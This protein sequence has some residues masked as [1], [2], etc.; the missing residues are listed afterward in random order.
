MAI[1]FAFKYHHFVREC[2]VIGYLIVIHEILPLSHKTGECSAPKRDENVV[3]KWKIQLLLLECSEAPVVQS[4]SFWENCFFLKKF[5][6][7]GQMRGKR[8]SF[9]RQSMGTHC[10]CFRGE[11]LKTV[12][13]KDTK[14]SLALWNISE[15]QLSVQKVAKLK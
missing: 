7:R 1:I 3:N 6:C 9:P 14:G 11:S 10:S 4:F 5:V 8:E 12:R 2:A 15:H 13:I